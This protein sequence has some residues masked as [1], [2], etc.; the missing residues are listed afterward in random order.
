MARLQQQL[1]QKYRAKD[2][3]VK[4]SIR[5]DTDKRAR[6]EN[7]MDTAQKAASQGNMKTLFQTLTGF[8][9]IKDTVTLLSKI[10]RTIS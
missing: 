2:K 8:V 6:L 9:M 1:R 4:S 3:E 7:Q 10:S 5:A